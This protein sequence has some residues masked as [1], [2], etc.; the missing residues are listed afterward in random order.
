MIDKG[1]E[2]ARPDVLGTNEAQPVEAFGGGELLRRFDVGKAASTHRHT[3]VLFEGD[4]RVYQARGN[5]RRIF[6]KK[7]DQLRD[8]AVHAVDRAGVTSIA[9]RD[10][11]GG[12]ALEKITSVIEPSG[13]GESAPAPVIAWQ[14]ADSLRADGGVVDGILGS[15][16]NLQAD[17]FPE[18]MTEDDLGEPEFALITS[19]ASNDTLFVFGE[20]LDEKKF[21]ATSS[22]YPFPFL[23][24]EWKAKQIRKSPA[25][26]MGEEKVD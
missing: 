4:P 5:I 3:F 18:G 13:G 12:L 24:S 20:Y 9:V 23:L 25:E 1:T 8:R 11:S 15:T 7:V 2:R 21:L 10:G 26:I 6:E 17:G 16:V 22:Q 19:G 14:T